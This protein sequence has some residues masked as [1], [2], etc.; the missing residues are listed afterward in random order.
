[1]K[2]LLDQNLSPRTTA[3]LRRLGLEVKDVRDVGLW[4]ATDQD[5]YAFAKSEGFIL[6]TY[7]VDFSRRYISDKGLPGLILLRVHPQTIEVLHPVLEDF[8]TKVGLQQ[9]QSTITTIENHRYRLRKL[10]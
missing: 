4:G 6:V 2:F 3:F 7:D 8:F 9:L 1:M 10:R 5:I